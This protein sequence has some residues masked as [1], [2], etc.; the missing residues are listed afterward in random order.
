M[1]N[2]NTNLKLVKTRV[3][4]PKTRRMYESTKSLFKSAISDVLKMSI[5]NVH[6]DQKDVHQNGNN[7]AF[8]LTSRSQF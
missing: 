7:S 1:A 3:L 4:E 8:V 5:D 6:D 2:I